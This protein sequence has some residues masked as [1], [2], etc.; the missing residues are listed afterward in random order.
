MERKFQKSAVR[1]VFV[2][3]LSV[4]KRREEE[5]EILVHCKEFVNILRESV[6]IVKMLGG[7]RT[8]VLR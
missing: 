8:L 4:M 7:V 3:A 5:E 6:E 1:L 2:K